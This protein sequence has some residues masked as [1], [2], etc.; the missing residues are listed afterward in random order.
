[1]SELRNELTLQQKQK[2]YVKYFNQ[3]IAAPNPE[4]MKIIMQGPMDPAKALMPEN[5]NDLLE[6]GYHEVETGYCILPN[7]AAYVAV[8]NNFPGA[9]V[10]MINW[11]FA[12]HAL[13]DLRYMLWFRKGHY[14]ISLSDE[15]REII[16]NPETP[17]LEKF[18]G[19]THYVIEN[20][21]GGIEDIQIR[22][23][24]PEE[25]GFDMARYKADS[26][27]VIAAN[28]VS[29][30]RSGGPK[31]PA[32]MIH[33]IREVPGGVESRSRFWLGYHMAD[34]KP[35]KL[36]PE[37]I[38][39]PIQVPMGLAFHNIEEYSNLAAILPQLYNE[40][41]GKIS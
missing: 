38:Q 10:E 28:G 14:G 6:Q 41:E 35:V 36:L 3:P 39:I 19:L 29:Q 18:Q 16:L 23:L 4:L 27:T 8:N 17:V 30:L 2:P 11:W 7:G 1:M 34:K 32:I 13:E 33:Y 31:A 15:D 22:F 26:S 25:S 5:I 40:M 9:T 21:G 37:G 12:W 20:T 24:T